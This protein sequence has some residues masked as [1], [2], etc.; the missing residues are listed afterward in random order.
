VVKSAGSILNP[1]YHDYAPHF[2][3]PD[4]A[5]AKVCG[6]EADGELLNISGSSVANALTV[7]LAGLI[8]NC[9]RLGV[10]YTSENKQLNPN[11]PIGNE[12]LIKSRDHRQMRH[13]LSRI[14]SNCKTGN[15]YIEVWYIFTAVAMN[16]RHREGS[17]ILQLH[18]ITILPR[19]F[20]EE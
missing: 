11:F 4:T 1:V 16:L 5:A 6:D 2:S 17:R 18:E 20:L 12:D 9:V 13:S 8:I 10:I 15:K 7:G 14:G 19:F 3:F